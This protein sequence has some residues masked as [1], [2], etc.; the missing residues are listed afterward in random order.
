[1]TTQG[2][3]FVRRQR[4][5]AAAA[6]VLGV[7]LM[8]SSGAANAAPTED[9]E[10][11]KTAVPAD[12]R[13][14]P[15][16]HEDGR[17]IVMMAA[18]PLAA[19][20]GGV[21]G[22]P[23]TK[24]AEG[25]RLDAESPQARKYRQYLEREQERVAASEG[26]T[27]RASFTTAVNGF[28][29]DLTGLQAA[30]LAK[31]AG[32]AV[33]A[34]DEKFQPDYSSTEYLQ[35][36][37]AG[38]VW[39]QQFGSARNAGAGTVVGVLDTGYTPDNPF[40]AGEEVKPLKGKQQPKVG[41]PYLAADGK[42]TMLKADGTTFKGECQAG[43]AGSG[44]RGTECNSKVLGARYYAEE[45][46][47]DPRTGGKGEN[48]T[49]SPLDAQ[50][51]GT[52]T[53]S[54]A[55]GNFGVRTSVAGRDFGTGSGVAPAAK[56]AVY[57]ICWTAANPAASGCYSSAAVAAIDQAYRDGVDVL[58]Y[59]ISGN[60]TSVSDPVSMAFLWASLSGVFVSAS[61]G[62]SGPGEATVNHSA[63]WITTVG[64]STFSNELQGTVE[65]SDG[66]KYRGASIMNKNVPMTRIL[67]GRDAPVADDGNPATDEAAD[68]RLCIRLD[69]AKVKGRIVVCERGVNPRA[70]KSVTVKKAGGVGM[71][72]VNMTPNTLDLDLH[73][74]PTVHINDPGIVDK[75]AADPKLTAALVD[76][77]TT[78][79]P[80]SP[81]PQMAAFSG[82]GPS[83]A[84]GSDLLK[85][86]LAAPGV[87]VLAGVSPLNG[88][89][90]FG[91]LSGTSMAA[92][93]VS[94]LGALLLARNPDWSAAM[95][96]S[97]LMT[98]AADVVTEDG[99]VNH[100]KFAT[101]AGEVNPRRMASPG[102]VYDAGAREWG[103]FLQGAGI[104][105]GLD[106]KGNI[107][108]RNANVP[109][110]ALGSLVGEVTVK[111]TVTALEGGR[112]TVSAKVPGI[113]V[114][115]EPSVL[116]LGKG[117]KA[118]YTVTFRNAGAAFGKFAMG[119]LTWSG[120]GNTVTS[121]VAVRPMLVRAPESV[122]V[123][124][125][126]GKGEAAIEV[127]SGTNDPVDLSVAGM[128]KADALTGERTADPG[129]I[130]TASALVAQLV[131]PEGTALARM[132][133]DSASE[134]A[135]WDLYVMTPSGQ[136]LQSVNAGSKEQLLIPAPA[137]GT[138][139]VVAHLYGT[140]E[141]AGR[142]GATLHAVA[143]DGDAGN[144]QVDPDPLE[145]ANGETGEVH[146]RWSGL[147]S[148]SW[149]GVVQFG[150]S[151]GTALTVNIP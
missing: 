125:A 122:S 113:G 102:L 123:E 57:K 119:E 88:G 24:P 149:T 135:D 30:A 22:L 3:G 76:H 27:I 49:I 78:G 11:S 144:L 35:L 120:A 81:I 15:G 111:R 117:D 83:N 1:M 137:A 133:I 82:R 77:D 106:P 138:Y 143:V 40:F 104:N 60:N 13:K 118:T 130:T 51:H 64:A 134:G 10:P 79:L 86:D 89:Q 124:S 6:L 31:S 116:R 53:A 132:A 140:E 73:A 62:N 128:A 80:E 148:G 9:D 107:E 100:D 110:F 5:R 97:A 39:E 47:R 36:P 55:A 67:L 32:V 121:P 141:A 29:A 42:I 112:Y 136:Q 68:A 52:H 41:E 75:V 74:V 109:S 16:L 84:V 151:A 96:K 8:I 101:G 50:G 145:L 72:L 25:Q 85:P 4:V 19:Y 126:A 14:M 58:N 20:G 61:A 65:L 115:V 26:V 33:V 127:E 63:P 59:S 142:A 66:T 44:F 94:G 45:F 37:G 38:G 34:R 43:E 150:D 23:A 99:S 21:A 2:I 87:G 69:A 129:N 28:V 18:A 146:A 54:T 98:T 131:V 114:K 70:E 139:Q 48:E 17:Y 90:R 108:P 12:I 7:S 92:P 91:F 71:V 56:I 93:Q 95:V 46:L 105:L 147:E 103:G